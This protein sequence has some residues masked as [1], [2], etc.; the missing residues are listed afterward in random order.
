MDCADDHDEGEGEEKDSCGDPSDDKEK[1]TSCATEDCTSF[2]LGAIV[3]T[4]KMD[5]FY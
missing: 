3:V 5:S 1:V 4:E 2:D